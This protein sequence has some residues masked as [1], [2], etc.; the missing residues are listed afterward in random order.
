MRWPAIVSFVVMCG[1]SGGTGR[2]T[3]GIETSDGGQIGDGGQTTDGGQV[4]RVWPP[5]ERMRNPIPDE[6]R[7]PG[8]PDWMSHVWSS[9]NHQIEGYTDRVSALAGDTVQVMMRSDTPHA[10]TWALYRLGWYGGA[11]ARKVIEGGAAIEIGLQ[12]PC[13][14]TSTGLIR[15][16]WP[17]T[18]TVTIPRDAVSGLYVIRIKRDDR[19][20]TFPP[21]VVRDERTADV[22][23]QAG[24]STYQAYNA[25]GGESLYQDDNDH[26]PGGFALSVS[27]LIA[28]S[29]NQA[30]R[31][32]DVT[33]GAVRTLAGGNYGDEADGPG[34]EAIFF[35][36]TAVAAASDG[37]IIFVSSSK[38][39]VK[40]IG[41]DASRTVTTLVGGA[42]GFADGT[43]MIGSL[44][45]ADGAGTAALMLPQ[46]GLVWD[47]EALLVADAG[48]QRIRR[49]VPGT[50][51]A[52]TRVQTWAGTGRVGAADGPASAAS[53][54]LPLGLY[55]ARD[56]TVFVADGGAGS[57][58]AIRP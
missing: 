15:C 37:R 23:F 57:L 20:A 26:V 1:C 18:F 10:A 48:N 3:D 22:L 34:R 46:G 43:G 45:F 27:F 5:A 49:V 12:S 29:A 39:K 47:G 51:A 36:P 33:T 7:L 21:L 38:G 32:L 42:P 56:G 44:G 54:G 2:A 19:Y 11:G 40:V 53:F 35:F 31:V 28:D 8:D 55:R 6:N 58:R 41:A 50:D 4:G 16:Q 24:V 17:V 25:W 30:I 52:S 9:W 13:P 14:H